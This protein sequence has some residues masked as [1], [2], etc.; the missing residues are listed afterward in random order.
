[1]AFI[2][3]KVDQY[4][5]WYKQLKEQKATFTCQETSY[6]K[7]IKTG[8]NQVLFSDSPINP[9]ELKLMNM[10]RSSANEFD[11]PEMEEAPTQIEFYKFYDFKNTPSFEGVKIDLTQAYW[12][13]AIN[14]GLVTPDIQA[15]FIENRKRIGDE[16][17]IKMARLRALGSLATKKTVKTY[18]EGVLMDEKLIVNEPHRQ[19]YLY[20]CEKVAEVMHDIACEFMEHVRYYYWDC[21]FLENT[22][23]IESVQKRI[24]DLGYESKIEGEGNYSIIKEQYMNWLWDKHNG[25]K[26]PIRKSDLI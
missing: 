20:I 16:K 11:V 26:Y 4:H 25:V 5:E 15:F 19:L 18:E 13:A 21:V 24:N 23:D 6:T 3:K 7:R 12:Q 9:I 14:L 8:K 10:I 1:M 2:Q 22:V 17:M